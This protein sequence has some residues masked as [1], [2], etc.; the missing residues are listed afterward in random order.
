MGWLKNVASRAAM[1]FALV[2]AITATAIIGAAVL[3]HD[4]SNVLERTLIVHADDLMHATQAQVAAERLVAVGRGYL[5]RPSTGL[6]ARAK[7]AEGELD[8]ALQALDRGDVDAPEQTLL[9][10]IQRS[11]GVYRRLLDEAFES[12]G[13]EGRRDPTDALRERLL[14]AREDLG[15][16]LANLVAHKQRLQVAARQR[17]AALATRSV[18]VTLGLGALAL[19]LSALLAK[20]FTRRLLETSRQE[21]ASTRQATQALASRDE[22]LGIVAHD[23]RNPLNAIA[24]RAS[25]MSRGNLDQDTKRSANA[26]ETICHR[27]EHLIGGL[28]DAATIEAGGL[29]VAPQH[30][31]V[32]AV[33]RSAIETFAPEA[34]EKA[35][36][37]HAEPVSQELS[38]WADRERL[39]QVL[40]N[41]IGNALKFTPRGGAVRVSARKESAAVR[42]EITDTGLG[43]AREHLPRIFERYWKSDVRSA[44]GAGLGLYIAKGI[45]EAQGGRIWVDSIPGIG[46]SFRLELPEPSVRDETREPTVATPPLVPDRALSISRERHA[47]H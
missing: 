4:A 24:L 9:Q 35:I 26:I 8:L 22:L 44:R 13:G 43:I 16:T 19:V 18:R 10:E 45:V 32:E 20:L 7:E 47:H 5:L 12:Q 3:A 23:L 29:S 30:V 27:M 15:V 34:N 39:F 41:L 6:L 11:A 1:G 36:L 25:Q 38:V 21:R 37:L 17:A 42:F 46:S 28:L 31:G 40:S 14:P 33:I 2:W